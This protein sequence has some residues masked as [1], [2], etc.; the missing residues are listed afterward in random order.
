M[1]QISIKYL[2]QVL[3]LIDSHKL[4]TLELPGI[5]IT[6]PLI[7]SEPPQKQPKLN[8]S[9]GDEPTTIEELDAEINRA[10]GKTS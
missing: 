8:Q 9:V 6:K 3:S 1:D 4:T 5:K 10:L 2:K 7:L